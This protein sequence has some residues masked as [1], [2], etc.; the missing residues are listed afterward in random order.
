M[1]TIKHIN[2]TFLNGCEPAM[3][4]LCIAA[5]KYIS[6]VYLIFTSRTIS[7]INN[8]TTKKGEA[9]L[10]ELIFLFFFTCFFALAVGLCAW[11]VLFLCKY[12]HK[13]IAWILTIL[14]TM[15][16]VMYI[17]SGKFTKLVELNKKGR[18]GKMSRLVNKALYESEEN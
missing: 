9:V 17:V 5:L 4:Y 6:I 10:F 7:V 11:I 2:L 18:V 14:L 16:F 8:D 3:V 13:T 1:D 12:N 15:G